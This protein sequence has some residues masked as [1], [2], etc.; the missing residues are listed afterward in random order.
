MLTKFLYGNIMGGC[1][2]TRQGN[3]GP[4]VLPDILSFRFGGNQW[5]PKLVPSKTLIQYSKWSQTKSTVCKEAMNVA[6]DNFGFQSG[7]F[8]LSTIQTSSQYISMQNRQHRCSYSLL[9]GR[10]THFMCKKAN[11]LC[12]IWLTHSQDPIRVKLNR[13]KGSLQEGTVDVHVGFCVWPG[14]FPFPLTDITFTQ[15]YWQ[16]C[17]T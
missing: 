3:L 14:F 11:A 16:K 1:I 9:V 10:V 5:L 2:T 4:Q 15:D 12:L 7:T 8:Q 13:Q 6:Q 17:Y